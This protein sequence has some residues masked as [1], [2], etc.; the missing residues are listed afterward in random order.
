MCIA[1][2]QG[3]TT[4][5]SIFS[6]TVLFSQFSPLLQFPPPPLNDF[7]TVFLIQK[8]RYPI[9]TLLYNRSRSTQ[10]HHLYKPVDLESP[11]LHAKIED[12][13]T[14]GSG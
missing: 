1:A 7:V 8:C 4:P 14:S 11:M 5:W 9:F 10:G 3:Q 12:H 13:S 2:G 6:L